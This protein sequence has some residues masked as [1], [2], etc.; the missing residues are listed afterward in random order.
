MRLI[1]VKQFVEDNTELAAFPDCR[2]MVQMSTDYYTRVGFNPPWISYYA[3]ENGQLVGCGGFK[4]KPVNG[5]VEIAYYTFPDYEQKGVGSQ[6]CHELVELALH[7][8]PSVNVTARTMPENNYSSRILQ[9]NSFQLMGTIMDE[10]DGVVWE[11][12]YFEK[13]EVESL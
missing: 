1:P 13:P 3:E 8:D 7:A 4:G 10:E 9:K 12:R 6:M 2:E 5:Q 11:W